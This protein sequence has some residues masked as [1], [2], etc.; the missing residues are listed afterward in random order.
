MVSAGVVAAL[1]LRHIERRWSGFSR[2]A[3]RAP[4]ISPA[5]IVLVGLYT[6]WAG[7]LA[8]MI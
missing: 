2:F 5:L 7:W 4:Y 1:S 3:H 6:G 8:L